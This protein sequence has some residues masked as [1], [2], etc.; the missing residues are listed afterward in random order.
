LKL[1]SIQKKLL[2]KHWNNYKYC[3]NKTI[4]ILNSNEYTTDIPDCIRHLIPENEKI[5]RASIFPGYSEHDLRNMIVPEECNSRTEW[6]LE[7]GSNIRAQAVFQAYSA[8]K[9]CLSNLKAGNIKYF[10]LKYKKKKNIKWTM[11]IDRSNLTRYPNGV[12]LYSGSGIMRT[13]EDFEINN[14]C[15]IHFDGKYYFILVPR[16]IEIKYNKNQVDLTCALDPGKRKFHT[17]YSEEQETF[18]IG[19]HASNKIQELM[20]KLDKAKH[21]KTE[22]KLRRKIKNLQTEMHNKTSRFL[23]E[24]YNNIVISR[25]SKNND[26]FK[27]K[28]RK[29]SKK[30]VRQMVVLGHSIFLEKLKAK[31]EEYHNVQVNE[32]TEE[33]TSQICPRCNKCTKTDN[34]QFIC[35]HCNFCTDRDILGSR[36]IFL[37]YYNLLKIPKFRLDTTGTYKCVSHLV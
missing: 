4:S 13:N 11:N 37:K 7:S 14:D 6:L 27:K 25:L 16:E 30:T 24:N 18:F 29:L 3:Y 22:L 15:K 35:K 34:E 8:W 33:Y 21:Q 36:N 12:S 26:I 20:L 2:Q 31:A 32:I 17:I 1:N 9:T 5:Q 28:N 19:I 23:C 10:D